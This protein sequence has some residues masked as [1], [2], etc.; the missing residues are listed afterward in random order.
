MESRTVHSI[1]NRRASSGFLRIAVPLLVSVIG[2]RPAPADGDKGGTTANATTVAVEPFAIA[3]SGP[4]NWDGGAFADSVAARLQLMNVV[5]VARHPDARKAGTDFAL[6]GDVSSRNGRLVLGVRLWHG[7]DP[8]PAWTATFW[9]SDGP[10]SRLV[11]DVATGAAEALG[12]E[13]AR[14]SVSKGAKR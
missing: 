5:T 6:L 4:K 10:V 14:M 8:A 3:D 1:R 12:A 11:D 13:I 7:D 2:C 9:R